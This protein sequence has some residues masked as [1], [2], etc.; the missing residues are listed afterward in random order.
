MFNK[1]L[2]ALFR[3]LFTMLERTFLG[4]VESVSRMLVFISVVVSSSWA[5]YMLLDRV[6]EDKMTSIAFSIL[7]SISIEAIANRIR[8]TRDTQKIV[9]LTIYALL[10]IFISVAVVVAYRNSPEQLVNA[11]MVAILCLLF[12]VAQSW[13]NFN[14]SSKM[15]DTKYTVK[16]NIEWLKGIYGN[17]WKK[18]VELNKNLINLPLDEFIENHITDTSPVTKSV[19][20]KKA[21]SVSVDKKSHEGSNSINLTKSQ[22]R[23]LEYHKSNPDVDNRS[24]IAK[25]LK[26]SRPTVIGAINILEEHGLW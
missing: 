8:E 17:K 21:E 3:Q 6:V 5:I 14:L 1:P 13:I 10:S 22:Q 23:V 11:I 19:I 15:D 25:E 4:S 2:D 7:L 26:L 16:N 18:L 20:P 9:G 12:T 24:I